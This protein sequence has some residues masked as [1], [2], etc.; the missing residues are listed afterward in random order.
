[1]KLSSMIGAV[2]GGILGAVAWGL[3]AKFAN[4]E[5][6]Y[7]AV[8]VGALVGFLST[9]LGGRGMTNAVACAVIAIVAIFAGKVC[10]YMWTATPENMLESMPTDG[11]FADLTA[12]ERTQLAQELADLYTWSDA[13]EGARGSLGGLDLLFAGLGI[14]AAFTMGRGSEPAGSDEIVIKPKDDQPAGPAD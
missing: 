2:L 10:S 1:M 4:V 13:V 12:D 6:G 11:E 9:M 7:V 3:V 14:A 5:V 8:G